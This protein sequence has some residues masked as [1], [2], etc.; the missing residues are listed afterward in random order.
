VITRKG[1]GCKFAENNPERF[2]SASSFDRE[3]GESLSKSK[4]TFSEVFS[5]KLIELAEQDSR[6][7]AI[8][9][10]M[11]AGTGLHLFREKLPNR[12][13]DVGIAESHAVSFSAGLAKGGLKPVVAIYST[14]L[15]RSFDQIVH[16]VALQNLPVV[17]A[18]DRAGAVGEDGPT[19]HGLFDVGYLRLIPNMVCM[20]PKDKEEFQDMLEFSFTLKC[21]SSIRYPKD[22]AYSLAKTE[23]VSL[24][25]SQILREGKDLCI[26]A[27]GSMVKNALECAGELERSGISTF[28]VNA[29]FIKPLDEKLLEYIGD[30]F[31][32]VV[33]IE[34]ANLNCGFGSAVI[35]FYQQGAI[36]EN[37]KF[38]R[39]GFP[40]E[41]IAFA[42]REELFKIYG[43]DSHALA[44]RIKYALKEEVLWQK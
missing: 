3:T 30:N 38:I 12:L 19:H 36:L 39:A 35:E 31:K 23:E 33:I 14:F 27:L 43:L 13:Y 1:K 15:Q 8:T 4:E 28:L 40:D 22:E 17:F 37:I 10:A 20:A 29:R 11:P 5:K 18:I 2:H 34:E 21:P 9:A 7:V 32:L 24:G 16:D 6:I 42:K 44:N 25:K 41:F 26:I